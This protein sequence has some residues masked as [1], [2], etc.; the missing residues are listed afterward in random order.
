L[1]I[2]FTRHNLAAVQSRCTLQYAIL[3]RKTTRT[4][5]ELGQ[6]GGCPIS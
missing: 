2:K 4:A 6:R 3:C 5:L 1:K